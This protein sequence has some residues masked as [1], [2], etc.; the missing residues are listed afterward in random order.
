MDCLRSSLA[1]SHH[2]G[3][4][5]NSAVH[6]F[7]PVAAGFVAAMMLYFVTRVGSARSL[8]IALSLPTLFT[9]RSHLALTANDG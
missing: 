8:D 2:S 3:I 7:V 6:R 4:R 9:G 5:I 1:W